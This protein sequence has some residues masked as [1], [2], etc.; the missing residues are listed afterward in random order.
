M[1]PAIFY[2]IFSF[3]SKILF[4]NIHFSSLHKDFS[5]ASSSSIHA[6]TASWPWRLKEILVTWIPLSSFLFTYSGTLLVASRRRDLYHF[7]ILYELEGSFPKLTVN[8]V[9]KSRSEK[10]MYY[11]YAPCICSTA[12]VQASSTSEIMTFVLIFLINI[13]R[14]LTVHVLFLLDQSSSIAIQILIQTA[15]NIIDCRHK[16]A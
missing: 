8:K 6:S 15:S 1:P 14:F 3:T 4:K 10:S 2:W 9:G 7:E 12:S 5:L 11:F 13:I 16:R